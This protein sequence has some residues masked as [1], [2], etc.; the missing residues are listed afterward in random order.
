M[1]VVECRRFGP[2][3]DLVVDERPS[4]ALSDG[5][6]RVQV[7]ACG[8]NFVDGLIVQGR[9]QIKP[10]LPFV[11][12]MEAAGVVVE[13][14]P[15]VTSVAVGDRVLA[16]VGFGG[17]ASEIVAAP[18][19]LVRLPD[20][21]TD[22]QAA[23]FAQSYLTGL[24]ALR[25]RGN[26]RPGD[27]MLVLGAGGGVG[28][29]AVDLG[30]ALGLRVF[31]VGSSADKREL[32]RS[33]G[34]E[35]TIDPGVDDVKAVVRDLTAPAGRGGVDHV[36]DPVGGELGESCLRALGENGQYLVIGFAAGIPSLP[37]NQILLRNRRVTGVDWGAWAMRNP[38]AN[39][40]LMHEVLS[41]I[42][43]R[44]LSPVEPTAFPLDHVAGALTD[45]AE[46]RVAGK[47][48]LVPDR[49]AS[50]LDGTS[51][52][53]TAVMHDDDAHAGADG[54]VAGAPGDN[55]TLSAVVA[56]F[57]AAG[58]DTAMELDE[59]HRTVRCSACGGTTPVGDVTIHG[60]RRLEGASDPA[61]MSAVLAVACGVC[62]A[63]GTLIVR[64]GPEASAGEADLLTKATQ[65]TD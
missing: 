44:R 43:A 26:V 37:A 48:V 2:V 46:R 41:M 39:R 22:G 23:S 29:A 57:E 63:K 45:L 27:S 18:V 54:V 53:Y 14:G 7:H 28:L 11:P 24:F 58:F 32:A 33:R 60:L 9:Y 1:R 49:D 34:A 15:G 35:V 64:Y 5:Q 31:A 47:V 61:D 21:L 16:N 17:Y 30:V 55:T 20:A 50:W 51:D 13:L 19:Q 42:E 56:E 52:G 8:V 10:P 25:E 62:T 6:V 4:A 38:D 3:A 36:Y 59:R 65:R 40:G 12:G